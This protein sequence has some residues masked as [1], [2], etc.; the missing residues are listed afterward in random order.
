MRFCKPGALTG[1]IVAV[2]LGSFWG[3]GI[4]VL[5]VVPTTALAMDG[6]VVKPKKATSTRDCDQDAEQILQ[7]YEPITGG[8]THDSNDT[9]FLDVNLSLKIQLL[10]WCWMPRFV[11][12]YFAMAT[13]FG[14]Y[15]GS[16]PN[17][18]VI[19]KS[20]NPLVLVRFL[21]NDA[22]IWAPDHQ[23]FEYTEYID[24]IPYAHQSN[25]QL[26]HT[27]AEY[28]DQLKT[29]IVPSYTNNFIHRGWDY[30]GILWKRSWTDEFATYLEGRYFIPHG[31]LQ[32]PEDEYHSWEMDPQG[33][34][35]K[36]VDGLSA[37]AEFPTCYAHSAI[38]SS[39]PLSRPNITVKYLTGYD[40]PFRYST[41]RIELG[42]QLFSL[43]LALWYQ[44]GYMSSL[45]M[46]YE[47][48]T[49]TGIEVRFETL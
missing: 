3:V 13:R 36:M 8:Y 17:S 27:Q 24:L 1:L 5:C 14:F 16:R 42:F 30:T 21:T 9:G 11:H 4:A 18:P 41:E 15:W 7:P 34:P 22:R 29:L 31:F 49:S 12:P 48:V 20:Y 45:A 19:G 46:Y 37:T 39:D 23:S 26:I 44:H 47:K 28:D 40:T 10:P 32:G 43:P 38:E 2:I 33:K 35:R 6:G 25:G